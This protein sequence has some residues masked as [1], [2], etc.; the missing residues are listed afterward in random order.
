M[1]SSADSMISCGAAG[2]DVEVELVAVGEIVQRAREQC[3]V[4]LQADLLA[5]LH[6]V[7]TATLRKSGSCK[8]R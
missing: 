4:V 3:D 1:P 5:G 2:D 6:E 7:L 8:M